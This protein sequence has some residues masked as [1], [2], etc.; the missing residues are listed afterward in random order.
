VGREAK[1]DPSETSIQLMGTEQVTRSIFLASYVMMMMMMMVVVMMM[2]YR[3]AI[4]CLSVV[5]SA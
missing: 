3:V 4:R 2:M 1:G 5:F